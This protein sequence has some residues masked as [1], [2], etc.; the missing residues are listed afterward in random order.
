MK[1]VEREYGIE[2]DIKENIVSIIVLED[3]KLRLPL[4][5]ELFSQTSGNEGNWLLFEN[6]KSFD[7]GKKVE[8][9]LEPLTLTLNNKKVKT[10]LYQDIKTIAQDYC[11]SQGLEVH[12]QICNYLENMLDKLPYPVK[13]DEDWDVS[14]ILKAYN[15][16]LV[17]E[18]DNIF[19]KLYNYIKLVNTVCG[20]DIF[21]MVNIKQYLTDDQITEL[22]KMAA[23]GKI[24][25]VLIEFSINNKRDCE[26]LYILDNDDCV[27]TY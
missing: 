15:V 3:V 1:L 22:Y 10:K 26:E 18:Y 21:I 11:F 7:L 9:I 23:Y 5:N 19:E 27:I 14:E 12:S 16:E 8:L 13:Y 2:V 6:D 25:L 20:T 17:E 4:I 24:Q